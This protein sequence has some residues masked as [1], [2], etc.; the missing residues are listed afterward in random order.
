MTDTEKEDEHIA[1]Q[2][3]AIWRG[4]HKHT[5]F[6]PAHWSDLGPGWQ[7]AM[8]FLV[9]HARHHEIEQ[10]ALSKAGKK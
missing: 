9:A 2:A 4:S 3:Y 10:A 8:K 7:S 5:G 6:T 1:M